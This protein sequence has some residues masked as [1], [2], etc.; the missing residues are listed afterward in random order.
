MAESNFSKFTAN[1]LQEYLKKSWTRPEVTVGHAGRPSAWKADSPSS[2]THHKI[3]LPK[4]SGPQQV[5]RLCCH[6]FMLYCFVSMCLSLLHAIINPRI[7]IHMRVL[8]W[9]RKRPI[10]VQMR[11]RDEQADSHHGSS[12]I[13]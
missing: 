9:S 11:C 5:P 4:H 1:G 6:S 12:K 7:A 8:R 3:M 13:V 2:M 10:L